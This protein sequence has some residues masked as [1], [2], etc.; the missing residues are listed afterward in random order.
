MVRDARG[1]PRTWPGIRSVPL[2]LVGTSR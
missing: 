2:G 1:D